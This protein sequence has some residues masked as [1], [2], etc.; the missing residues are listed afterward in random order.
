MLGMTVTSKSKKSQGLKT[1]L[2]DL[3]KFLDDDNHVNVE[4]VS[5][6]KDEVHLDT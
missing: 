5:S 2:D 1:S 3:P 6:D 4:D